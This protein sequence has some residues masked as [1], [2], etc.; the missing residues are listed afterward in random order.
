MLYATAAQVPSP[1]SGVLLTP[2]CKSTPA[3]KSSPDHWVWAVRQVRHALP[4]A[5]EG[6]KQT[7][8]QVA[9]GVQH[10]L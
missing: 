7:A 9:A 3:D 4:V 1:L 2:V 5:L 8:Q 10:V 6:L